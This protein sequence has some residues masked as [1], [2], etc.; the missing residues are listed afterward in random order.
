MNILIILKKFQ[1]IDQQKAINLELINTIW[2]TDNNDPKY[3]S[4]KICLL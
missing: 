2:N 3:L 4:N 1:G